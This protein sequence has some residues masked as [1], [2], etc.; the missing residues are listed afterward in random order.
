MNLGNAKDYLKIRRLQGLHT[1]N[2][3]G[4]LLRTSK[5][6]GLRDCAHQGW[7]PP[8]PPR[9]N[10]PENR[11]PGPPRGGGPPRNGPPGNPPRGGGLPRGGSP[12]SGGPPGRG[13]PGGPPRGGP[14]GP[15]NGPQIRDDDLLSEWSVDTHVQNPQQGLQ[16]AQF[17]QMMQTWMEMEQRKNEMAMA[18]HQ[19]MALYEAQQS[20]DSSKYAGKFN[21]DKLSLE[22]QHK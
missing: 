7:Y 17:N 10:D 13:P 8:N 15:P 3:D 11:P 9:G 5:P 22:Q 18:S 6:E 19:Q 16:Q 20:F 2:A 1:G 12:P 4:C 21:P 14:P